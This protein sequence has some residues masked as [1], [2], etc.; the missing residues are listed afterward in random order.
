MAEV[1][2]SSEKL[3]AAQR[4]DQIDTGALAF[5]RKYLELNSCDANVSILSAEIM[6]KNL[7]LD[8][9]KS[10]ETAFKTVGGMLAPRIDESPAPEPEPEKW[11]YPFPEIHTVADIN[12]MDRKIYND[13][14]FD[15]KRQATQ[16]EIKRDGGLS[17]KAQDFRRVVTEI[18]EK[19]NAG[20]KR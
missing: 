13:F 3:I 4:Q 14:W 16:E 10:W 9:I 20:R 8:D 18:L 2:M 6:L 1:N 19:A 11:S 15:K 17:Q 5:F 7:P 12:R